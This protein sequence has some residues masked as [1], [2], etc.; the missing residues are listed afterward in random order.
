MPAVRKTDNYGNKKRGGRLSRSLLLLCL[1]FAPVG[2]WAQGVFTLT[3]TS[4]KALGKNVT[5]TVFDGDTTTRRYSHR[6]KDGVFTFSAPLAGPC[7]AQ[8]SFT[9]NR[10]LY[11]YIEPAEMT[12]ELNAEELERSP[13]SGSR[14]NSQYRYAMET[15]G[16]PKALAEYLRA[17][18]TSPIA[19]F[20]LFRQMRSLEL[21]EVEKLYS[22]LDSVE[23]RCYHYHAIATYLSESVA[24]AEG[25]PL[26]D[27]EFTEEGQ[28]C[29]ISD[30]LEKGKPSVVVFGASWCDICSRDIATAEKIC[31]DS[32]KVVEVYIDAD[33][34]GWDVPYL[35][36]LDISHLPYIIVLDG[37]GRIAGRDVRIWELERTLTALKKH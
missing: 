28:R 13:L 22:I 14:S 16:D 29:H 36:K 5:L 19:A 9:G 17:N 8:L 10:Q 31:R 34:R 21:R 7:V 26:P 33:R 2:L 23:A 6:I 11:I 32:V 25:M 30:C 24:L 3:A 20:V 18:R 27:F 4:P 35:A 37:E 1:M 12:L 15:S